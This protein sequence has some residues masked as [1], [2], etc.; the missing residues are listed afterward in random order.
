MFVGEESGEN[1]DRKE[2]KGSSGDGSFM[3]RLNQ[4]HPLDRRCSAVSELWRCC[5]A[6]SNDLG[7]DML[8]R[9]MRPHRGARDRSSWCCFLNDKRL[10]REDGEDAHE[11]AAERHDMSS[12]TTLKIVVK[13]SWS[14]WTNH[15]SEDNST[16]ERWS[17]LRNRKGYVPDR[18]RRED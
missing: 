6:A 1:I 4:N 3:L 9:G 12:M 18:L 17:L 2:N 7:E 14:M 15:G 16:C 8:A 5:L 10:C 11:D 13:G